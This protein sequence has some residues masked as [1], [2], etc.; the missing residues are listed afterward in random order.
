MGNPIIPQSLFFDVALSGTSILTLDRTTLLQAKLTNTIMTG[1]AKASLTYAVAPGD[2]RNW[3]W[4][5]RAMDSVKIQAWAS[6]KPGDTNRIAIWAGLLDAVTVTENPSGGFGVQVDASTIWKALEVTTETPATFEQRVQWTGLPVSQI[7]TIAAEICGVQVNVVPGIDPVTDLFSVV[8]TDS[9][10]ETNPVYQDWATIAAS[11]STIVGQELFADESGVLQYR[12]SQYDSAPLGMIPT[13][14]IISASMTL[15]TD[16]GIVNQAIVRYG[17]QGPLD[18]MQATAGPPADYDVSHY[19]NRV[20][21][22]G[23]PWINDG[24]GG[25]SGQ[26]QAQWYA[27][28]ALSWAFHNSRTAV[29][30]LAFWPQARVGAVYTLAWPAG[31]QTN[32][33]VASVVHDITTGGKAVTVLG[34]TYGR[35]LN[36]TW[37]QEPV[38]AGFG[39]YGSVTN[40]QIAA[41]ASG[42]G[43]SP[44]Q[45]PTGTNWR[46][47]YYTP[48][49]LSTRTDGN[50]TYLT[51]AFGAKLYP[52]G[53]Q[54]PQ[55]L[56]LLTYGKLR[57]C[58]YDPTYAVPELGGKTISPGDTVRLQ[59]GTM[60]QCWD[61]GS[62]VTGR[63][64]DIFYEET[65]TAPPPDYQTAT[66]LN[67]S[68]LGLQSMPS[69]VPFGP[70]PSPTPIP[71]SIRA[72]VIQLATAQLGK[73]Y[74]WGDFDPT[75]GFDCSGLVYWIYVV[76]LK[77]SLPRVAQDQ[78]D[79]TARVAFADLLPGDLVFFSGTDPSDP[80]TVTH[81][82]I[83]AGGGQMIA[84]DN[85]S[86][87]VETTSLSDQYWQTHYYGAGRVSGVA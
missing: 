27:D 25:A 33:Y 12:Q 54:P 84:A 11:A 48:K 4:A 45:L 51:T 18:T 26:Q 16:A 60:V 36:T 37:F 86:T 59:D 74:V 30:S 24:A 20:L 1:S 21:I 34:L 35:P 81:V 76:M 15:D 32:F 47:T 85:T 23:A 61:T 40:Q 58:A 67:A 83:Y 42:Q 7:V 43:S 6:G 75:T 41:A 14:R 56:S 29:V 19:R 53:W 3:P 66:F 63:H 10:V 79:A 8:A 73:P 55:A 64:L 78:Y 22:I 80:S 17:V 46:T 31:K 87:G 77:L 13:E 2:P 38:P 82:G 68:N 50:G 5:L 49:G 69:Q 65:P 39:Q 28:W 9:S 72:R 70:S 57:P 52:Q 44:N 71:G 62:A